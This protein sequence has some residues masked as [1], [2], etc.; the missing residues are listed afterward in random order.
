MKSDIRGES[1]E[2]NFNDPCT[3]LYQKWKNEQKSNVGLLI[4][5]RYS[6]SGHPAA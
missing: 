1:A 2:D 6:Y 5:E 3:C 4:R